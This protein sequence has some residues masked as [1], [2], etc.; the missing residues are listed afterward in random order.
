MSALMLVVRKYAIDKF[1]SVVVQNS[2]DLKWVL[3]L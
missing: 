3:T 1:G 2:R